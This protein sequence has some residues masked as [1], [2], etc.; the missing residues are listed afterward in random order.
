MKG[1]EHLLGVGVDFFAER[2]N[3]VMIKGIADAT[4]NVVV[5]VAEDLHQLSSQFKR[6]KEGET[7][8]MLLHALLPRTT[9]AFDGGQRHIKGL[10]EK[11]EE[12]GDV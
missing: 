7:G 2:R 10:R 8:R 6:A 1:L 5:A 3:I 12:K 11:Y 4:S 9:S